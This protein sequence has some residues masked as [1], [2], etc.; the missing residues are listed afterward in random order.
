MAIEPSGQFAHLYDEQP[1]QSRYSTERP[2]TFYKG[3]DA[4]DAEIMNRAERA[5]RSENH[6]RADPVTDV[7]SRQ[8]SGTTNEDVRDNAE[9]IIG[10]YGSTGYAPMTV[11]E[12]QD[13]AA[14]GNHVTADAD[15]VARFNDKNPT[16][17]SLSDDLDERMT[18]SN[19][20]ENADDDVNSAANKLEDAQDEHDYAT[21]AQ[22]KAQEGK[23]SADYSLKANIQ[24]RRG[25]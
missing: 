22:A 20:A 21:K 13:R 24:A 4:S 1:S 25:K 8:T 12:A 7:S 23:R 11:G 9:A 17:T 18:A 16:G 6:R 5:N 2:N 15:A 19:A 14:E 3:D 10:N